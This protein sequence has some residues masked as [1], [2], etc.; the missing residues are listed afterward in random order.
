M[1][2]SRA[3]T[4]HRQ[5]AAIALANQPHAPCT[6]LRSKRC[7]RRLTRRYWPACSRGSTERG[8][9][10]W[11]GTPRLDALGRAVT[12]ARRWP[13]CG[14]CSMTPGG[15]RPHAPTAARRDRNAAIVDTAL[16]EGNRRVQCSAWCRCRWL[17][18]KSHACPLRVGMSAVWPQFY[19]IN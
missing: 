5:R 8:V 12:S 2:L 16:F 4:G 13:L 6:G 1:R 15:G 11:R 17:V 3:H 14:S 18:S 10:R 19:Y 9:T 7:A